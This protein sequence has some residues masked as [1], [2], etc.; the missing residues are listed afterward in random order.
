MPHLRRSSISMH[1]LPTALPWANLPVR[2]QRVE[3]RRARSAVTF[4]SVSNL[5]FRKNAENG[6]MAGLVAPPVLGLVGAMAAS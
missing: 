5:T 3:L 2:L 1:I 4:E 6:K